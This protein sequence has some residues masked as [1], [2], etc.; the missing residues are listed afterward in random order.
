MRW[1]EATP[2]STQQCN[3]EVS[4]SSVSDASPQ[5]AEDHTPNYEEQ[6]SSIGEIR[7]QR[8]STELRPWRDLAPNISDIPEKR[9]RRRK[10]HC[11]KE[12][13]LEEG[14]SS[15][16]MAQLQQLAERST[17]E[18]SPQSVILET[19]ALTIGRLSS[20]LFREAS[21]DGYWTDRANRGRT[22][23]SDPMHMSLANRL[24]AI[25]ALDGCASSLTRRQAE[26][27]DQP[28]VLSH[29]LLDVFFLRSL[30]SF[31]HNSLKDT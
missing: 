27:L 29:G 9:V 6:R 20:Q 15:G 10:R 17:L 30:N 25:S 12:S 11:S 31:I 21:I 13:F 18:G 19:L 2:T 22:S 23:H 16:H 26:Q 4:E 3:A 5:V 24:S 28:H 7:Q 8:T 14:L 1:G